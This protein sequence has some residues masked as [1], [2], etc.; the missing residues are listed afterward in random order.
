MHN[1]KQSIYIMEDS[2]RHFERGASLGY[3]NKNN[4]IVE[5]KDTPVSLNQ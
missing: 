5:N 4:F 1:L 2:M 3:D